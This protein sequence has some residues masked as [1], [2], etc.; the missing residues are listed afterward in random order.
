[1]SAF[2]VFARRYFDPAVI[3]MLGVVGFAV[4]AM[5][6]TGL[7]TLRHQEVVVNHNNPH[8]WE[9]MSRS[10]SDIRKYMVLDPKKL[11]EVRSKVSDREKF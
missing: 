8:P 4:T 2:Q 7:H 9:N 1:M 5:F 11:E 10:T 3:P 6:A